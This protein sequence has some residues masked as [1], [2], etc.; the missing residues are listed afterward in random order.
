MIK[1]FSIT[2]LGRVLAAGG[3]A[4][5]LVLLVRAFGVSDYA[6]FALSFSAAQAVLVVLEFGFGTAVLRAGAR[7]PALFGSLIVV[8]CLAL[9]CAVAVVLLLFLGRGEEVRLPLA[10]V[11]LAYASG[12]ALGDLAVGIKQS[13]L[14]SGQ[15]VTILLIRRAV[16]IAILLLATTPSGATA[17][18]LTTGIVGHGVFWVLAAKRAGRPL[19]FR[20]LVR[21]NGSLTISS[22]ATGVTSADSLV[23]AS[24]STTAAVGF[25]AA[26][27]RLANPLNLTVGSLIQVMVP[28]M[29]RLDGEARDLAFR[30][31]R[32]IVI[33][34]AVLLAASAPFSEAIV[35]TLYG[36][37]FS[38]SAVVLSGVIVGAS[39]S[40]VAQ[41]HLAWLYVVGIRVK[42][43]SSILLA[44]VF[45]LGAIL[46]GTVLFGLPGA[47]VGIVI[48]QLLIATV[49]ILHWRSARRS[50]L[51]TSSVDLLEI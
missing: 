32:R 23:V 28:H 33:V 48:M 1:R 51:S 50:S 15:A 24:V 16:P 8:R 21:S 43:S 29:A 7:S 35:R 14:A 47:A 41:V 25:Y 42:A 19:R 3:Q 49:V 34:V 30:K 2:F 17:A 31:V 12:E 9:V 22:A 11:A 13:E 26:S 46:A 38:P 45:G 5:V 6:P 37:A 20:D 40:A 36:P 4:V 44:S 18:A 10:M 27:A 39:V